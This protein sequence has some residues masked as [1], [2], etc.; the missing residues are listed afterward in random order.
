MADE[1]FEYYETFGYDAEEAPAPPRE[2]GLDW[3]LCETVR[4]RP[5]VIFRWRRPCQ[6]PTPSGS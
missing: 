1:E 4:S 2:T 3:T 5:L 6:R